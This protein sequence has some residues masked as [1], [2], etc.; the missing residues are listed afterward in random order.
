MAVAAGGLRLDGGEVRI[1]S[2]WLRPIDR[3]V[4]SARLT[5]LRNTTN[6]RAQS[7]Q[8]DRG[9]GLAGR[10]NEGLDKMRAN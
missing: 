10:E 5:H 1:F 8:G 7:G 2:R 3:D 9:G 6:A 4:M